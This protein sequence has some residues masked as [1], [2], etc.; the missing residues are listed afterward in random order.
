M[1]Y[2]Y[3]PDPDIPFIVHIRGAGPIYL[4]SEGRAL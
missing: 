3:T 4:K 1:L 2:D